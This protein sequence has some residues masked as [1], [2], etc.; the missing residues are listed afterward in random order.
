MTTPIVPSITDEQLA[1][2]DE[3]LTE[4][5]GKEYATAMSYEWLSGLMGRLRAAEKDAARYRFLCDPGD[6]DEDCLAHAIN[7]LNDWAD[8][9]DIDQAIDAAMEQSK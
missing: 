2:I 1:Q 8:K 9:S 5:S 4:I 7:T 3:R 6:A